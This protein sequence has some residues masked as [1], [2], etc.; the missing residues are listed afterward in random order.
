V[1]QFRK[2][3]F[4]YHSEIVTINLIQNVI[5]YPYLKVKST[6]MMK[7]L[8]IISVGFGIIDQILIRFLDSSHAGEKAEA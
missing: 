1:P 7:L 8:G 6:K 5:K 4:D 3:H 2:Y